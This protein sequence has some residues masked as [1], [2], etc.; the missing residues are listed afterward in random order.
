M[1]KVVDSVVFSVVSLNL[2]Y[3]VPHDLRKRNKAI[4][5]RTV[6]IEG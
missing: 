4:I 1:Q 5:E 6:K 2:I 3:L